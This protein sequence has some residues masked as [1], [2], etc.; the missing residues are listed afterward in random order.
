MFLT[1]LL[2]GTANLDHVAAAAPLEMMVSTIGMVL[3]VPVFSPEQNSEIADVMASKYVNL[4]Y[5]YLIRILSSILAIVSLILIFSVYLAASGCEITAALIFGTIADAMFL[6]S[7]GLFTA[8]VANSLPTSFMAPLLYYILNL[9]A[10]D[11]LGYLNLFS[12]MDGNHTPDLWLFGAS[13]G[14]IIAAAGA[15]AIQ[16][17]YR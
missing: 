12:M 2:F 7:L 3:L 9:T 11:K 8:A 13:I 16:L 15:K 1:P 6:G 14:L 10:K 4:I 5:I 17:K